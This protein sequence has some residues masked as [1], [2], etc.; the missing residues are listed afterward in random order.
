MDDLLLSL[1][2]RLEARRGDPSLRRQRLSRHYTCRCG[3]CVYFNDTQCRECGATLGYLADEGRLAALDETGEK[4]TWK[5]H[6]RADG[7][8]FCANQQ[9]AAACN[10]MVVA[11]SPEQFCT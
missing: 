6:R 8:K 11:D 5:T 4:G 3:N 9:S 2:D 1:S 10:W 7:L